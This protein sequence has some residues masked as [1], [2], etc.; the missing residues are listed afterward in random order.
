MDWLG[1][2]FI[3]SIG[4]M[5][6]VVMTGEAAKMTIKVV[7]VETGEPFPCFIEDFHVLVFIHVCNTFC[8]IFTVILVPFKGWEVFF[9]DWAR[10]HFSGE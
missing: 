5:F 3:G 7:T 6:L 10:L 1:W 2:Y 9:A 8:G 4:V